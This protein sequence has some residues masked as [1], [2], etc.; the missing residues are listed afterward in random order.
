MK[1]N[2]EDDGTQNYLMFQSCKCF[3]IGNSDHIAAW[4]SKRFP[5]GSIKSPAA[6]NSSLAP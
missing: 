2:F 6:F 5:N 4:K 3:K 1:S